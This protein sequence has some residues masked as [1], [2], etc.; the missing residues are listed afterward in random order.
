MPCEEYNSLKELLLDPNLE[1]VQALAD[2]SH[3][4]RLPL[5]QSLLKI[6]RYL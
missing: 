2:V 3:K 5:A 6:F 1:A 4:D